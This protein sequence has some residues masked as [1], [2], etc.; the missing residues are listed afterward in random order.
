M[1][2][3]QTESEK[4]DISI[5][6]GD[7]NCIVEGT[8]NMVIKKMSISEVCKKIKEDGFRVPHNAKGVF[9]AETFPKSSMEFFKIMAKNYTQNGVPICQG[10]YS[11]TA[12]DCLKFT[13]PG[14]P[15]CA[16]CQ[17]AIHY[18]NYG[19]NFPGQVRPLM[20]Y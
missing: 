4:K 3:K 13:L 17:N 8:G 11:G 16:R 10:T 12:P 19:G 5:P 18:Y 7:V 14:Q 1:M 9:T 2:S 6:H 15:I 20:E